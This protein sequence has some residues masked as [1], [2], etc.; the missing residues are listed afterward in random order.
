MESVKNGGAEALSEDNQSNLYLSIKEGIQGGTA[1]IEAIRKGLYQI[2]VAKDLSND[3]I[4]AIH[5]L[6]EASYLA[7]TAPRE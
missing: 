4:A 3:Q 7:N 5:A 1:A 6:V 2:T